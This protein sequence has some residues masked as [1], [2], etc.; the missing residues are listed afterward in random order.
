M[1]TKLREK[2]DSFGLVQALS[3]YISKHSVGIYSGSPGEVAWTSK[4]EGRPKLKG[5][6]YQPV[7]VLKEARGKGMV[8]S[9]TVLYDRDNEPCAATV[10][11]RIESD[12]RFIAKIKPEK[13]VLEQMTREEIIGKHGRVEYDPANTINWFYL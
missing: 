7:N 4:K 3:W 11:G 2:P 8:E 6:G 9:Y 10:I 1:V 13:N 12:N 5:E